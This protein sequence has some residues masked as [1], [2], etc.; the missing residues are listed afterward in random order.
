MR[1]LRGALALLILIGLPRLVSSATGSATLFNDTNVE[2]HGL[3]VVFDQPITIVRRGDAFADWTSEEGGTT[4]VFT[5]GTLASWGDFYFFW[6]PKEAHLVGYDWEHPAV[7]PTKDTEAATVAEQAETALATPVPP[8][9]E[10]LPGSE[11]EAVSFSWSGMLEEGEA[12]KIEV[13]LHDE[14]Y[15]LVRWLYTADKF[16]VR[17]I[18]QCGHE[19]D[20]PV[21]GDIWGLKDL[22]WSAH[23]TTPQWRWSKG[24]QRT[25]HYKSDYYEEAYVGLIWQETGWVAPVTITP[26]SSLKRLMVCAPGPVADNLIFGV[27]IVKVLDVP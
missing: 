16:C 18:V 26:C 27:S 5:E 9:T 12:K 11:V 3:R 22:P 1:S 23:Q 15:R 19:P 14:S 17:L 25:W 6:V 20:E 21:I 2:V 7:G 24:P 13:L 8:G 4:I 10:F